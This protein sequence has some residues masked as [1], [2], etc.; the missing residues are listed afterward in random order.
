MSTGEGRGTLL[1]GPVPVALKDRYFIAVKGETKNKLAAST[2]FTVPMIDHHCFWLYRKRNDPLIRSVF[3]KFV[4]KVG[5]V[6]AR[7]KS[8]VRLFAF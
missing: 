1:P 6:R 4:I 3:L 2:S 5:T 8:G 7:V